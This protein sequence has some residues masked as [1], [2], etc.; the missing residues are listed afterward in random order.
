MHHQ[1][2]LARAV[3]GDILQ[4]KSLRQVEIKL[5][6]A[7]LPWAANGVDQLHINLR[8]VESGLAGDD[9]VFD[10]STLEGV[11]QRA[12]AQLPLF[13]GTEKILAIFGIPG[14]EFSLKLIEAEVFEDL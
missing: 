5:N 10:I 9:L 6:S 8:A 3:F 1:W 12:I 4:P 7:K 11:L 13:L 2:L 14:G